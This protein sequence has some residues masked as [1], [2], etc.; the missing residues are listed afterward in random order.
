MTGAILADARRYAIPL[1]RPAA[2]IS[3]A[4]EASAGVLDEVTTPCLV[5]FDV[6]PGNVFL[7]LDETPRIQAIIDHERAFWGDPLADFVTPTIFGELD[8]S[9]EIVAGYREAGGVVEFTASTRARIAL[10]RLYLALII[11]TENGPRQY[12]EKEYASLRDRSSAAALR[13]LDALA[14]P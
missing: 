7:T 8:E 6:W 5:H 13:A 12:P 9:D 4:I 2:E 10:Y 1:P 14:A 3:A 11:L